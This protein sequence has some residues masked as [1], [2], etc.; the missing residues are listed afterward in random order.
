MLE[1]AAVEQ[2]FRRTC[3][4][5]TIH[6]HH[7]VAGVGAVCGPGNAITHREVKAGVLPAASTQR[8]QMLLTEFHHP[9]IDL[10]HVEMLDVRM[11][12]AFAGGT[13]VA[14]PDHQDPFSGRGSAKSRMHQ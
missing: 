2:T 12:K 7:V 4:I 5:G 3:R 8:S 6:D 9:A 1:E 13:A 14:T 10:H 11:A